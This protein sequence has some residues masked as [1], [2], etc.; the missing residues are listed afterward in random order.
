MSEGLK[1][2][3]KKQLFEASISAGGAT[4]WSSRPPEGQ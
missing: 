2:R 4:T 3:I 1:K